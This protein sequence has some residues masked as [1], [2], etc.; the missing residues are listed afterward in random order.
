MSDRKSSTQFPGDLLTLLLLP[1]MLIAFA[2]AGF[3]YS[4]LVMLFIGTC[5]LWLGASVLRQRRSSLLAWTTIVIG[6][7]AIAAAA[8]ML[9]TPMR[10]R[11]I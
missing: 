3:R 2:V 5:E 6:V 9:F 4:W 10:V 8:Y 1:A 11:N 7:A